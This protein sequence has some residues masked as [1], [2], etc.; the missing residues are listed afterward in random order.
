M[1]LTLEAITEYSLKLTRSEL[2]QDIVV[3]G[4]DIKALV[5]LR[6][7]LPMVPPVQVPVIHRCRLVGQRPLIYLK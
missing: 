3:S 5:K 6:E 7:N 4:K 1:V 2:N